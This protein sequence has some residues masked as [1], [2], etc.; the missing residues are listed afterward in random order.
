MVT[1]ARIAVDFFDS[2]RQSDKIAA[3]TLTF[4]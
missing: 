3:C 2:I 4:K 1:T